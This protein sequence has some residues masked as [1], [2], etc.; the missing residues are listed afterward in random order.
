LTTTDKFAD[1]FGFS[2]DVNQMK[3]QIKIYLTAATKDD[4]E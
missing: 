4:G 1:M 3:E 2:R